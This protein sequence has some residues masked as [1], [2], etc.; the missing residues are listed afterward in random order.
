[1]IDLFSSLKLNSIKTIE[2][3]AAGVLSVMLILDLL[4]FPPLMHSIEQARAKQA[5]DVSVVNFFKDLIAE[6][7]K[8]TGMKIIP[9]D[10]I[11]DVLDKI[12]GI[13]GKNKMELTIG[14]LVE[15]DKQDKTDHPYA[16]KIFSLQACGPFKN[17]GIFLT[18]LRNLP[19]AILDI[20]SIHIL[21][22]KRDISNLQAQITFVIL[23][24]KDDENK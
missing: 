11:D 5:K 8:F 14:G 21:S 22:D 6:K 17:L 10:K 12:Q 16:R 18:Q 19:D 20:E 23:T 15:G 13:A 1:M 7:D 2:G 9:Q 3:M 24:T 4:L